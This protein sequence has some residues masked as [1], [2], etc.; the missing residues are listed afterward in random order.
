[1][2]LGPRLMC[3]WIHKKKDQKALLSA[4]YT[5]RWFVLRG[6]LLLYYDGKNE[7]STPKAALPSILDP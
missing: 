1:M 3:G 7:N 2:E 4:A 6:A 5:K